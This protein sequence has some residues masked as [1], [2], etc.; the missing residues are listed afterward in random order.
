MRRR[1]GDDHNGQ[2]EAQERWVAAGN[3]TRVVERRRQWGRGGVD[4]S[5]SRPKGHSG[6]GWSG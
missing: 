6:G 2:R 5:D 4:Y 1:Q 3:V